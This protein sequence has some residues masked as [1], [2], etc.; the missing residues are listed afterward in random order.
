MKKVIVVYAS[1]SGNTEKMA[2]I[3][4][5]KLK[6]FSFIIEKKMMDYCEATEL[7]AYD[8]ILIGSYT[9][10]EGEIPFE[11][12]AFFE[13]LSQINLTGQKAAVF[14]SGDEAYSIFCG[15]VSVFEEQLIDSGATIISDGLKL[16]LSPDSHE[17]IEQCKYFAIQFAN[18]L[19]TEK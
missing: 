9:Y 14:G 18:A 2:D 7:L 1:M 6:G 12:E 17:E 11:A 10:G 4:I 5:D 13:E 3:I 8:G 15:A 19:L 16:E